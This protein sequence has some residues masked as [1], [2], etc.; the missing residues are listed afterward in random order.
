MESMT[1]RP[2]PW[3]RVESNFKDA[4]HF[5]SGS[6]KFSIQR[7]MLN[8]TTATLAFISEGN[9]PFVHFHDLNNVIDDRRVA[10]I[11]SSRKNP[12]AS[13]VP[14]RILRVRVRSGKTTP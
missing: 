11:A 10:R 12:S 2:T 14:S 6:E 13:P 7:A 3:K 5:S 8:A 9:V 1:K 4:L